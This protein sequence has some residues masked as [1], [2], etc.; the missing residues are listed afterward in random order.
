[1]AGQLGGQRPSKTGLGEAEPQ[2]CFSGLFWGPSPPYLEQHSALFQEAKAAT[3]VLG[4]RVG[5]Q[6]SGGRGR[7]AGLPRCGI[8]SQDLFFRCWDRWSDL[9]SGFFW[10]FCLVGFLFLLRTIHFGL[11]TGVKMAGIEK[12]PYPHP[13]PQA[14]TFEALSPGALGDGLGAGPRLSSFSHL[15]TACNP[16]PPGRNRLGPSSGFGTGA[17]LGLSASY[18]VFLKE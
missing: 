13:W 1:M 15:S 10:S 5:R 9:S 17:S 7:G 14:V 4:C 11:T 2:G 18:I 12:P 6:E 8:R 3:G 16:L